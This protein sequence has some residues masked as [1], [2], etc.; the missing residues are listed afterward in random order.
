M[1]EVE[2]FQASKESRADVVARAAR[3]AGHTDVVRRL[4]D[5]AFYRQTRRA[6]PH[7]E[8]TEDTSADDAE[9]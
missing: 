8:S 1:S 7:E 9:V 6:G 4:V 3:S 2:N 5:A